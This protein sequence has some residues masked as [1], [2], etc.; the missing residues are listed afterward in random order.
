MMN[1]I[2]NILALLISIF[3]L[4]SFAHDPGL[5]F[6][7]ITLSPE[8]NSLQA[9]LIFAKS[10]LD[11]IVKIDADKNG[12]IQ[13]TSELGNLALQMLSVQ[14]NEKKH[15][16]KLISLAIT[17]KDAVKITL[18]YVLGN[19][20]ENTNNTLTLD[21]TIIQKLARGHRQY[22]SIKTTTEML[23]GESILRSD[24]H[25]YAINYETVAQSNT[26]TRFFYE[27]VYHIWIGFDHILFLIT[28]LLPAVLVFEKSKWRSVTRLNAALIS[29]IKIVTA[30][31]I[32]HSIT[33]ALAVFNII[34]IPSRVVESVIALSVIITALNNIYPFF[35]QSRWILAFVFGLVHGFGFA[36]VLTDLGL[37]N[38]PLLLSLVGFNLGVE[39]GQLAIVL[40]L[41]PLLFVIRETQ[42][43]RV[44][45]FRGGSLLAVFIA[46]I[47]LFER[48]FN[49][50]L[51]T[52]F[53]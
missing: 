41:L 33:L 23:V 28:L 16:P 6:A 25:T 1:S 37:S 27:G 21:A 47:W 43:Y 51:F 13:N 53:A 12:V 7:N 9:Q 8:K 29:T 45:I 14:Q 30:F 36:G 20:R 52:L 40:V 32:A 48:S 50:D 19:R 31:T 10:D 17:E 2:R 22:L 35:T 42:S 38:Q 26:F 4:S 39:A 5:S 18:N 15:R 49:I 3:S 46:A 11:L 44:Y 24:A 34:Y